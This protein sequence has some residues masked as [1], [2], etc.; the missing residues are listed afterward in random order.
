[1]IIVTG[2]AGFIGS[3][4]AK[5]LNQAG[6]FDLVLIDRLREAD[7]WKNLQGLKFNRYIMA[8]DFFTLELE[9]LMKSCRA[10]FHMG[11]CSSTTEKNVDYL[12]Q[13]NVEYSQL[14]FKLACHYDIPFIYA[15]S[16]A[17][18]GD[19]KHGYSE[20]L[21][22]ELR[23]LN[24]YGFSKLVFDQWLLSQKKINIPWFGFKFFNV[25]GPNEYHKDE[26]RSLVHKAY[27]QIKSRGSVSLFKSHRVDYNDGEQ[28]R[29][30]IYVKD[31]VKVLLSFYQQA[32]KKKS[33]IY[34]LGTG[35]A[36]SFKDLVTQVFRSMQVKTNIEYIDMP[37]NIR[38]QY[39]YFTEAHSAKLKKAVGESYSFYSLEEGVADYVES[40]L[41]KENCYF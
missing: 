30:F 34:N 31:V 32:D 6:E 39:Q 24:P 36:R 26:M 37:L 16:A 8:D 10:I 28:L 17:T 23:P 15:S 7:K 3:V 18:Y 29:D 21:N 41:M 11:A 25:Y 27:E 40:Y 5:S 4:L 35:K 1:M 22:E 9:E 20:D 33:G 13:N 19:G 12:M 2:A 38:D 14:M